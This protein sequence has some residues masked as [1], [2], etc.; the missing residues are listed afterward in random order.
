MTSGEA[1]DFFEENEDLAEV[2][3]SFDRGVKG[4]TAPP[5]PQGPPDLRVDREYEIEYLIPPMRKSRYARMSF[6][7]AEND[8]LYFN[9]RPFAGTQQL[10]AAWIISVRDVGPS[11]GRE[12][13]RRY[14]D[15]RTRP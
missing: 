2:L 5:Q 14:V 3:A 13:S 4:K 9:A 11:G 1:E 12:D 7:G 8:A 10:R 15:R 6:T